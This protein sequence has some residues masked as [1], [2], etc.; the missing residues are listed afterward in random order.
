MF[1]GK[2][3]ITLICA[4][5][6]KLEVVTELKPYLSICVDGKEKEKVGKKDPEVNSRHTAFNI[7]KK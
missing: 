7:V 5:D 6:L 3:H 1:F 4:K 2:F